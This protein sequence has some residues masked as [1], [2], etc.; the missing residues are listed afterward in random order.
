[1]TQNSSSLLFSVDESSQYNVTI[2]WRDDPL[3]EFDIYAGRYQVAA[4]LLADDLL[5]QPGFHDIDV[6]PI[7]FL[8]RHVIELYLKAICLSG[9]N[10][11]RILNKRLLFNGNDLVKEKLFERHNL[12]PLLETVKQITEEMS[13]NWEFENDESFKDYQD[14]RTAIEE[15]EQIDSGSYTFRYPYSKKEGQAALPKGFAFDFA[16]LKINSNFIIDILDGISTQLKRNLDQ[17]LELAVQQQVIESQSLDPD[18]Q[19]TSN[20]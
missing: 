6:C 19:D 11:F 16:S 12:P 20:A 3:D 9:Y 14:F 5:S 4:N 13:G 17:A 15:F 2:D 18:F 1:M 10:Y 7:V 8:Y